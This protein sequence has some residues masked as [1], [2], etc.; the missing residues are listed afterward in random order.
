MNVN[1][2]DKTVK[3]LLVILVADY[4]RNYEENIDMENGQL[5]IC[6]PTRNDLLVYTVSEIED[7][8]YMQNLDINFGDIISHSSKNSETG[9]IFDTSHKLQI[10]TCSDSIDDASANICDF[11][12]TGEEFLAGGLNLNDLLEFCDELYKRAKAEEEDLVV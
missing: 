9:F 5:N 12:I 3:G 6:D 7:G 2:F 1:K 8:V 10:K 11:E 4:F